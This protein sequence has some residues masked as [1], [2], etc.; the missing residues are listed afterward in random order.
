MRDITKRFHHVRIVSPGPQTF[1]SKV[2]LDGRELLGI[3]SVKV[4][5]ERN[6]VWHVDI[7]VIAESLYLETSVTEGEIDG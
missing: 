6:D 7:S 2:Y 1:G 3:T 4:V 5:G